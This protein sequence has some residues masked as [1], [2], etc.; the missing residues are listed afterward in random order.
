MYHLD[1]ENLQGLRRMR[2]AGIGAN[3]YF[4]GLTSMLTDV[5]SEMVASILPIYF[6]FSMGLTPLQ[7]GF[8]DGLSQG[9]A[10]LARL[11]SGV[12]ADRWQRNREVAALGYG[13]SAICRLLM[14]AAGSAWGLASAVIALDRIGKGIRTS[15]RDALISLSTRP[16][17]LGMAFG[18][19][20]A[21]DTA[22]ALLGPLVAFAI[23]ALTAQ[24]F[25]LV[26]VTSFFI[27]VAG[28]AALV[29]FVRN[30]RPTGNGPVD[31][32]R[33][34][35]RAAAALLRDPRIRALLGVGTALG[36][37]TVADAFVFLLL[38]RRL[39]TQPSWFPLFY[40]VTSL[41]YLALAIP[42]GGLGDRFGRGRMLLVGHALLLLAG[43]DLLACGSN[44][45]G[46]VLALVLLG[47]YYACTDG[48]LMAL[49]S[50]FVPEALRGSGLGI[51][52]TANGVARL[53]ASLMFGALWDWRSMEFALLVFCAGLACALIA[54]IA[55][56]Q[57]MKECR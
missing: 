47:A 52:A 37:F 31:A 50:R 36:L 19:H 51:V 28:F 42:A 34:T 13:L 53:L 17:R 10:A 43:I 27:A 41:A 24:A 8:V 6:V 4:L 2:L 16:E 39:S 15:P 1:A 38:Q 5:S 21:L 44:V 12:I 7:F 56:F 20:R 48:V 29:C 45:A 30:V 22:G 55:V 11:L 18:V 9:A 49:A 26:F 35:L 54:S 40:A 25:D 14:L 46:G 23:L 57:S 3:V 32:H 33:P